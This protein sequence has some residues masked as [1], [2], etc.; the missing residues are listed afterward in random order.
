MTSRRLSS[1]HLGGTIVF[2]AAILLFV[3]GVWSI[4]SLSHGWPLTQSTVFGDDVMV[5]WLLGLIT[6]LSIVFALCLI[7]GIALV[8]YLVFDYIFPHSFQ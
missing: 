2:L 7:G 5:V 3:F 8:L 6:I 1:D 4:G